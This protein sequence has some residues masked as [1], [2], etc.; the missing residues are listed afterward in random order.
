MSKKNEIKLTQHEE[1]SMQY[2][3]DFYAWEMNNH[4]YYLGYI[5]TTRL[6]RIRGK[7]DMFYTL[8]VDQ[9]GYKVLS[10][11]NNP[12][13]AEWSFNNAPMQQHLVETFKLI[14]DAQK[15][16]NV[17]NKNVKNSKNQLSKKDRYKDD[18]VLHTLYSLDL[19]PTDSDDD[20]TY[21]I[22]RNLASIRPKDLEVII[23]PDNLPD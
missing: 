19:K 17:M 20:L 16:P 23:I 22:K 5:P 12:A 9:K 2:D 14:G 1:T 7:R 8:L 13:L 11:T 10:K 15:R 6:Q 4:A 3:F 18:V 21:N